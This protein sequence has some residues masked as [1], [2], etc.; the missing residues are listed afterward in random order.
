M[1]SSSPSGR[2]HSAYF[3]ASPTSDEEVVESEFQTQLVLDE[4]S[5]ASA[6]LLDDWDPSVEGYAEEEVGPELD[7]LVL[8]VRARLAEDSAPFARIAGSELEV[9]FPSNGRLHPLQGTPLRKRILQLLRGELVAGWAQD[10]TTLSSCAMVRMLAAIERVRESLEQTDEPDC[11]GPLSGPQGL[12]LLSEVAHDL[13]SPLTSILTLAEALRRGQSGDV[14]EVQRR[15]LGLIYSAALGLSSTASDV[16]ELAHGGDS[17]AEESYPISINE[18]FESVQDIVQP[19]AEEKGLGVQ[20]V[21]PSVDQRRGHG[22]AL[23]RVLLNLTTNALKFTDEGFVELAARMDG[24]VTVEFSVRDTGR[25]MSAD[26]LSRLYQVFRRDSGQGEYCFSGTG[27]G[28]VICRRLVR[29]MGSDLQV[30]T[31]LGAGTRFYFKLDLPPAETSPGGR[32]GGYH[33]RHR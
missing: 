19:M 30:E 8:A 2:L 11:L 3:P 17:L 24:A 18:I 27:L 32:G 10:G 7:R 14:N 9:V 6:R 20:L 12:R 5:A 26:D 28:L 15:Q 4:L 22:L 13:R 16:T 21:V 33:R 23:G 29:A 25:G 1:P 31:D